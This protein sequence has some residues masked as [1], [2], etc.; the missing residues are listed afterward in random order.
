MIPCWFCEEKQ[1]YKDT[2]TG[3]KIWLDD[4]KSRYKPCLRY[5]SSG[6]EYPEGEIPIAYCPICGKEFE[7]EDE[8]V[9]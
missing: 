2:N 1:V 9:Y 8:E 7:I 3:S 4:V 6:D 5:D